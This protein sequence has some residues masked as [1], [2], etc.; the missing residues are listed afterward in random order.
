MKIRQTDNPEL[1]A[2]ID[3]MKDMKK[4]VYGQ[5]HD[6]IEKAQKQQKEYYDQRH[7]KSVV[8]FILDIRNAHIVKKFNLVPI[9]LVL[10]PCYYR[11]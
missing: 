2:F 6:N 4:G 5:V 1:E 8:S 3:K 7:T 10:L 9:Y 11:C